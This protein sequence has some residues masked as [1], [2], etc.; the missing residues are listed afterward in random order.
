[1]C[2][3]PTRLVWC[4]LL[5]LPASA[6]AEQYTPPERL[7]VLPMF[8]VPKGEAEPTAVEKELLAKHVELARKRYEQM[9]GGR[10]TFRVADGRPVVVPGRFP[11]KYYREKNEDGVPDFLPELLTAVK[12]TRLDCPYVLFAVVMNVADNYPKGRGRP[13]NGGYNSGGVWPSSRRSP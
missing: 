11:S 8:F 3:L 4:L 13:I 5:V 7:E 10:D 2:R 12:A 6:S 9:L 1:M